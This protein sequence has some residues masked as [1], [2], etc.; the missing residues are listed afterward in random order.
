MSRSK[1]P[2]STSATRRESRRSDPANDPYVVIPPLT[3]LHL[4]DPSIRGVLG[5]DF[6]RHFDVL[7]DHAEGLL[8]LGKSGEMLRN[9][10]GERIAL[11][12]PV[13]ARYGVTKLSRSLDLQCTR[14]YCAET[15]TVLSER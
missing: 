5:G 6:L 15:G 2:R 3:Q 4:A 9:V 10:H 14:A 1:S 11:A 8:C 13:R 7:V 12:A